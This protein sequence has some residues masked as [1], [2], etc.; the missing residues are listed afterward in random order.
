MQ[1]MIVD[2]KQQSREI[3]ATEIGERHQFSLAQSTPRC[4]DHAHHSLYRGHAVIMLQALQYTIEDIQQIS[5]AHIPV[6]DTIQ[7]LVFAM[8][9]QF[10]RDNSQVQRRGCL[11]ISYQSARLLGR[12]ALAKLTKIAV[13]D[14]PARLVVIDRHNLKRGPC[15]FGKMFRAFSR[16]GR[17][18]QLNAR[19]DRFRQPYQAPV[20][21]VELIDG[22]DDDEHRSIGLLRVVL[23][24]EQPVREALLQLFGLRRKL[25]GNP[26]AFA[27]LFD[28]MPHDR[29]RRSACL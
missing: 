9:S 18:Q 12:D 24:A 29:R 11:H 13:N 27:D 1:K 7:R 5:R 8:Q 16:R 4:P 10:L 17:D 3:N 2:R 21:L 25:V 23:A 20:R 6:D 26:E 22:I 28:N 14:L 19:R 15:T